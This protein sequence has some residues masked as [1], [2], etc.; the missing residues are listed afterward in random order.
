MAAARPAIPGAAARKRFS[1]PGSRITT[2]AQGWLLLPLGA[3]A[4]ASTNF[5][6]C[7]SG[8]GSAVHC[9]TLLRVRSASNSSIFTTSLMTAP[10]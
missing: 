3:Q 7:S 8:I 6:S 1:L 4:A 5:L 2:K 9:R 10:R